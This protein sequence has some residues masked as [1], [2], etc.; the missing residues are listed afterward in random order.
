LNLQLVHL[1]A[2]NTHGAH[3]LMDWDQVKTR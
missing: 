3:D 1:L 2:K